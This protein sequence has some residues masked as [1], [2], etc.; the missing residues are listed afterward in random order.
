MDNTAFI[1]VKQ[2]L[3]GINTL[4]KQDKI[5]AAA[6]SMYEALS[7]ILRTSLMK[8]EKKEFEQQLEWAVY[9][10]G[11]NTK[12]KEVFPLIIAYTP[13]QEKELHETIKQLLAT[14][15]DVKNQEAKDQLEAWKAKK[16]RELAK[17]Q[18]A[19]DEKDYDKAKYLFSKI[20]KDYK[21]DEGLLADVGERFLNAG[22]YDEA[23]KYLSEAYKNHPDSFQIFNKLG[24][25]LRKNKQFTE[26]EQF[27]LEALS[28]SPKNEYI[29]FNL[30]RVYIDWKKWR[31]VEKTALKALEIKPDF[32]EAQK[33]LKFAKKYL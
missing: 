8:H 20:Y 11:S 22:I 14:L 6:N 1:K 3:S 7:F 13:G 18:T 32:V 31:R 12:L 17:A 23:I 5:F 25:A 19:L 27:Y 26:A 2:Q 16:R 4:L 29:L 28:A 30:G 9:Q 15:Q 21:D 24:M 33:M 10:L